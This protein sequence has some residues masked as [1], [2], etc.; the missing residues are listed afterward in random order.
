MKKLTTMSISLRIT[1][2]YLVMM[3]LLAI[4][5]FSS[6]FNISKLAS[7]VEFNSGPALQASNGGIDTAFNIQ[8][9]VLKTQQIF[10]KQLDHKQ[11]L[12]EINA[13]HEKGKAGFEQVK[14]SGLIDED[15]VNQSEQ[16]IQAYTQLRDQS[17]SLYAQLEIEKRKLAGLTDQVLENVIIAHEDTMI[18]MDENLNDR[19][20]MEK[21]RD[22]EQVLSEMKT[23]ILSRNYSLQQFFD[24]DDIEKHLKVMKEEYS[25]LFPSYERSLV[26]LRNQEMGLYA[27]D[28]EKS[29]GALFPLFD[30]VV[31]LHIEFTHSQE[32]SFQE[33]Q[34]LL[35]N[36]TQVKAQGE[37]RIKENTDSVVS[38]VVNAKGLIWSVVVIGLIVGVIAMFISY[39]TVVKPVD[40][41]AGNLD[42]I[43]N[44]DGN[45]NVKLKETGARE[46]SMLSK[47]FNVFVV[48]IKNIVSGVSDAVNDLCQQTDNLASISDSTR[49]VI[50]EQRQNTEQMVDAIDRLT[51][52]TSEI[53]ESAANAATAAQ[54]ADEFSENG[55]DEVHAMINAIRKQ[56]E[57]LNITSGVMEKLSKDSQRIGEVLSVIDDIAE[58]TNLLALNAA[59]EAARAGEKGRGFA[60]VADEVRTLASNT[61][62]ATTKIQEVI[63]ELQSASKDA[64]KTVANTLDIAEK[65]V[66]QAERA[67]EILKQI[68]NSIRTI[69][70]VN[71]QVAEAT[72]QQVTITQTIKENIYSVSEKANETSNSFDDINSSV[73]TII[74]VVDGLEGGV[75]QF[76]LT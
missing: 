41:I 74:S 7:A 27:D 68:T 19:R 42:Q 31:E 1:L 14:S 30:R 13:L 72:H 71:M 73:E 44:G 58:Q 22:I 29:L 5:G 75:N 36:L 76:K 9:E 24:G 56:V 23:L 28:L 51:V 25:L 37:T 53:A 70:E 2:G 17:L 54:S 20:V 55:K 15:L 59:I 12:E 21:Y 48:R 57:Q 26:M 4:S 8:G 66:N 6:V 34:L 33:A 43:G 10:L 67:D 50:S 52:S 46:L 16:Q 61:Q 45:L 65:G 32:T 62:Q 63:S 60:V 64:V 47:G 69:N 49:R 3:L 40:T 38:L 11:G 18:L 35:S 39:R